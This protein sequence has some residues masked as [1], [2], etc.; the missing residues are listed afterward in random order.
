MTRPNLSIWSTK[1]L[2][3]STGIA[4]PTPDDA[5]RPEQALVSSIARSASLTKQMQGRTLGGGVKDLQQKAAQRALL[6]HQQQ[7]S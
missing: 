3:E 4:N 2:T 1:P 6:H 5:P 7:Q